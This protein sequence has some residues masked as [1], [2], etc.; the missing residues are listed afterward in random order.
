MVNDFE[1]AAKV[2]EVKGVEYTYLG[3]AD[4]VPSKAAGVAGSQSAMISLQA[5]TENGFQK[6]LFSTPTGDLTNASFY[7]LYMK[8]TGDVALTFNTAQADA[9]MGTPDWYNRM[10][11]ENGDKFDEDGFW[12][13]HILIQGN[14][15][16]NMVGV[17]CPKVEILQDG[18]FVETKELPAGYE[19]LVRFAVPDMSKRA[20]RHGFGIC[21]QCADANLS[22][23]LYV[24]DLMVGMTAVDAADGYDINMT[25]YAADAGFKY[26]G[27]ASTNPEPTPGT[28]DSSAVLYVVVFCMIAA[29]AAVVFCTRKARAK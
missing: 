17:E 6:L 11:E 5:N 14:V 26:D 8:W 23:D 10:K 28:G 27:V 24:D 12:K 22:G 29:S 9:E 16:V 15:G 25:D 3:G 20:D 21:L 1:T 2:E 19:G 13:K 18:K 7:Q 4:L